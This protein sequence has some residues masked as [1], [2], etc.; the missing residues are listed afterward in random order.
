MTDVPLVAIATYNEIENLPRLVREVQSSIP[1]ADVLVIDDNSPDGTGRWSESAASDDPR[2]HC[3]LRSGKLGLGSAHVVAMKYAISHGYSW[4]ITMDADFS[5]NPVYLPALWG[6]RI[7]TDVVIG[8]R[9]VRGGSIRG[10]PLRRHLM[11]RLVNFASRW[12]LRLPCRDCSGAFRVYRTSL[13]AST[14]IDSIE[15]QGYAFFEEVLWRLHRADARITEVPI[16]FRERERGLSKIDRTEAI[17][18]ARLILHL[19]LREWFTR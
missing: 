10:W 9:Y 11:S 18:A 3:V 15:S 17:A 1:D 6:A 4:L 13:L 2:L 5:H 14:V 7:Q 19:G 8:S 12:L 16:E